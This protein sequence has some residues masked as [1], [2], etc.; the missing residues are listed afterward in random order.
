MGEQL[1]AVGEPAAAEADADRA[2]AVAEHACPR[3]AQAERTDPQRLEV[4]GGG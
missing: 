1:D 3:P 2:L 4:G